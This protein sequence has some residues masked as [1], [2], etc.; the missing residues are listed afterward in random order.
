[1]SHVF[2]ENMWSWTETIKLVELG[3]PASS[4]TSET[5]LKAQ[6]QT[7]TSTTLHPAKVWE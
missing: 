7:A 4:A 6:K 5:H 3:G 1:M 2:K